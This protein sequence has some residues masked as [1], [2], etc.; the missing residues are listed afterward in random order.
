MKLLITLAHRQ[1]TAI[2]ISNAYIITMI[3]ILWCNDALFSI[4][5]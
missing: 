5:F 1:T 2:V 3:D 4:K